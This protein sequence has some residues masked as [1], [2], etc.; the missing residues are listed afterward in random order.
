MLFVMGAVIG[1]LSMLVGSGD[2]RDAELRD[3]FLWLRAHRTLAAFLAGA[4]LAAGG[5]LVQGLFRNPLA[6]PSIIGT[7]AGANLGGM[8]ALISYEMVLGG[9]G[10]AG[11]PA[12]MLLPAGCMAGAITSLL[13]LLA[14]V[15]NRPG[16]V[17]VLL[18][19]FIL[20]SLFA[21]FGGLLTSL[22]QE[23]WELGR[24]MVSFTL[25]GVDGKGSRH[26]ALALPLVVGGGIAAWW[27]GRHLDL[28]LSGEEE[29]R[30]L[31]VNVSAVRR[32]TIAWT[33][34]LAAAAVA[35][36]GNVAFVG[37]VVPHALR[38]FVGVEHRRLVPAALVG[39]G[40]FLVACDV[41]TRLVPSKG[42]MPLGVITGLV[43]APVFLWMLARS[44]MGTEET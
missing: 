24:A 6:S 18:T 32:W 23:S 14:I 38:P 33:A 9:Q 2:L 44:R 21:S 37:L 43:G 36:G 12:E 15:R 20:S 10:I 34:V 3:T 13:L 1:L 35:I 19:G 27:W 22:A 42:V 30:S 40:L 29:A 28:L 7:T 8:A 4:A 26:I 41:V 16:I 11:I 31:G 17:A 5:V 39:G 25:G